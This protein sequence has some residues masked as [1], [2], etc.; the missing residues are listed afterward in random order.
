MFTSIDRKVKSEMVRFVIRVVYLADE[1]VITG[2]SIN[3][4]NARNEE[5][6]L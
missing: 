4:L 3:L 6:Q 1:K 5:S 2:Y